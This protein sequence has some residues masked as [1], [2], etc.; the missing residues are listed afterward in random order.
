MI[1]NKNVMGIYLI[2][3]GL[4]CSNQSKKFWPDITL[5]S[6]LTIIWLIVSFR[7]IEKSIGLPWSMH[8]EGWP[9]NLVSLTLFGIALRQSYIT[10][11]RAVELHRSLERARHKLPITIWGGEPNSGSSRASDR[12]DVEY[13]FD[14]VKKTINEEMTKENNHEN[15]IFWSDVYS[16]INMLEITRD[17][18]FAIGRMKLI[19]EYQKEKFDHQ[20][21]WPRAIFWA[22]PS[23]G[24]LGTVLGISRGI[25]AFSERAS[26]YHVSSTTTQLGIAFDA[27]FVALLATVLIVLSNG[28][29]ESNAGKLLTSLEKW[30]IHDV[31]DKSIII[32]RKL[33]KNI[34]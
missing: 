1:K 16:I 24:F 15:K 26:T 19:I 22:I 8:L 12:S 27:T 18:N 33:D 21:V 13:L 28:L 3:I 17:Y 34:E 7:F 31:I 10:H 23:I 29:V 4:F 32:G 30:I 11:K 5:F 14:A 25:A 2:K 6:V 9:F 20:M